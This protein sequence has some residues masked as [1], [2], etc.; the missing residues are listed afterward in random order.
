MPA[1]AGTGLQDLLAGLTVLDA[2][3]PDWRLLLVSSTTRPS[4]IAEVEG[5]LAELGFQGRCW[6]QWAPYSYAVLKACLETASLVVTPYR[7]AAQSGV[8]ALAAGAGLP[9]VATDVGGLPEMVRPGVNGELVPVGNA[10]RL[11][12]AIDGVIGRLDRYRR[13]ARACRST[14]YS[15]QEA[16]AAV[17][18]ALCAAAGAAGEHPAHEDGR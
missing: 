10:A 2:R 4:E 8:L 15:P 17:A 7:W 11:A 13:G 1:A 14:L 5:R 3:L 16:A 12:E 18:G 9:V 6:R